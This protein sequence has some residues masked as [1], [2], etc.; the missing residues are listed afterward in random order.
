[1]HDSDYFY[2]AYGLNIHSEHPILEFAPISGTQTTDIN[3]FCRP[4]KF[5]PNY[6]T[7]DWHFECAAEQATLCFRGVGIFH[8]PNC[9]TII[10]APEN[11]ADARMVERYLSGVVFAV[12]LYLRK[13]V[14]FHA[15]CVA[16]NDQDAVAFIGDSGA[17]K[18]TLAALLHLQ[19]HPCMNDD[20]TPV[21]VAPSRIIA[22]PGLPYVKIDQHFAEQYRIPE[23]KI[24]EVHPEE[25]QIYL[26]LAPQVPLAPVNVRA[27]VFLQPGTRKLLQRIPARQAVIETIRYTLPARL[28]FQTGPK[29][30]FLR[31]T[32]LAK[33]VP[34]Y[35]LSR[36]LDT[37]SREQLAEM[38]LNEFAA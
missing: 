18:S 27:L 21:E 29:E 33:S 11:C 14:V 2:R 5:T 25:E 20:V 38:V 13:M 24:F 6:S 36:E 37:D 30:H 7:K 10:V 15:A 17:G 31:C 8:L 23:N 3:I 19:G 22:I 12:L 32:H 16:I 9:Q 34:A 4:L 26:S 28:L 1:M 35:M